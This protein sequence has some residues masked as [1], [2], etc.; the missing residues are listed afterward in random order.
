MLTTIITMQTD[1]SEKDC[2]QNSIHDKKLIDVASI[3]SKSAGQSQANVKL[4]VCI[5]TYIKN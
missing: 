3:E 1:V 2:F 5:Q 4:K